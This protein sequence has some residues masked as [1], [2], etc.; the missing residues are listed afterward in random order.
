MLS[1]PGAHV[2]ASSGQQRARVRLVSAFLRAERR[3]HGDGH[4]ISGAS[5]CHLGHSR[6]PALLAPEE[7]G[8]AASRGDLLR[9]LGGGLMIAAG[10]ATSTFSSPVATSERWPD[11]LGFLVAAYAALLPYQVSVTHDLNFALADCCL[12]LIPLLAPGQLKYRRLAWG[13]WHMALVLVF[14]A[15]TL[16]SAL[17]TGTLSRYALL[18]KDAGLIL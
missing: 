10:R 12:I 17:N 8:S 16:I 6:L 7:C 5:G 13:I 14:A 9:Q 11:V 2:F 4:R 18:N 3:R 15:G 1:H